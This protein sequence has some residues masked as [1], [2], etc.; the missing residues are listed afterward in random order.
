[1]KAINTALIIGLML[2]GCAT[3]ER[4]RSERPV[5]TYGCTDAVVIGRLKNLEVGPPLNI[6]GDIL[7]HSWFFAE[8]NVQK[9]LT[10]PSVPDRFRVRYISHTWLWDDR[11]F[12]FVVAPDDN[13]DGVLIAESALASTP[14]RLERKCG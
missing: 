7:G 2:G 11:S 1:M 5:L 9:R 6:E 12:V 10:G 3:V 8:L 4:A 13:V 14:P